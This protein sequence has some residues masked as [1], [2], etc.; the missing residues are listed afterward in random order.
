MRD[1]SAG[2]V[3]I[4][5]ATVH[6]RRRALELVFGDLE[7]AVRRRQIDAILAS[8]RPS[9]SLEGLF[10]ARRGDVAAGAVWTVIHPGRHAAVWPP[11]LAAGQSPDTARQLLAAALAFLGGRLV[12][13]VHAA[14]ARDTGDDVRVLTEAGFTHV[15]DLLHLVSLADRFPD[16]PPAAHLVFEPVRPVDFDRLGRLLEAT[17]AQTLDCPAL[18]GLRLA[19]DV[20]DGYRATGSFDPNRWFIV[21][22]DQFAGDVAAGQPGDAGC[23]LLTDHPEAGHWELM[24]MGLAPAARG[25][26]WGLDMVRHAQWLTRQSG[27]Q[28][29]VL[30]VDAAN[31]P[32][33]AAYA[34]AGFVTWDRRSAFL[35]VL[36]GP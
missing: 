15:A 20:L 5:P 27:R 22:D 26:G 14:L 19:R 33:I 9:C 35:K 16:S 7:P 28:R 30:A 1:H 11:R 2:L 36:P 18:N 21:R 25:R 13:L 24:Y 29:L 31:A 23:L 10:E 12:R 4:G 6:R 3:S 17:Y 34:A 32:A 8:G